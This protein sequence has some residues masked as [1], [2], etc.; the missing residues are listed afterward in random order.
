MCTMQEASRVQ[1]IAI[2]GYVDNQLPFVFSDDGFTYF[3][4]RMLL[5]DDVLDYLKVG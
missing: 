2:Y 3:A 1:Q 5:N 4:K